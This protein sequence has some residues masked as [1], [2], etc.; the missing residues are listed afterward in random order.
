MKVTQHACLGHA[1]LQ[2]RMHAFVRTKRYHTR[3]A[4]AHGHGMAWHNFRTHFST[5]RPVWSASHMA[6]S[7]SVAPKLLGT[8]AGL[9]VESRLSLVS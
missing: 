3:K 1:I 7:V 2:A 9:S 4:F 8:S 6:A 5:L